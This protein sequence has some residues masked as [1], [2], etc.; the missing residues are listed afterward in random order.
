[1]GV[2]VGY[3]TSIDR[4]CPL[5]PQQSQPSPHLKWSSDFS[6]R[7]IK[8][9]VALAL[10]GGQ[11]RDANICLLCSLSLAWSLCEMHLMQLCKPRIPVSLSVLCQD[12][13]VDGGA[14]V[15][16]CNTWTGWVERRSSEEEGWVWESPRQPQGRTLATKRNSMTS[17]RFSHSLASTL[18][19][20]LLH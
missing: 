13:D 1:M 7:K 14:E 2:T 16:H 17:K 18:L 6:E 15:W 8:V 20:S 10:K 9:G 12:A 11:T 5:T 4:T 3:I 19:H